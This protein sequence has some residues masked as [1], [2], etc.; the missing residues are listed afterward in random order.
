MIIKRLNHTYLS[1][2]SISCLVILLLQVCLF[3]YSNFKYLDA[4]DC[5][6]FFRDWY[7]WT[8]IL[9]NVPCALWTWFLLSRCSEIFY[10]FYK[11]AYDK[12]MMVTSDENESDLKPGERVRL[13]LN[14]YLE[15]IFNFSI[16]YMLASI[17]GCFNKIGKSPFYIW[18]AIYYS[19][20]TIT[21]LGYGDYVS[22]HWWPKLLAVYE[23]LCGFM[24]LIVSFGV[25]TRLDN[26][27]CEPCCKDHECCKDEKGNE[28]D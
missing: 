1:V 2:A 3:P 28:K 7:L 18:D 6:S 8:I 23:V 11:D 15:L 22:I 19:G 21:T 10:A 25:Y 5:N 13:A 20:V 17:N 14:S 27:K 24:L 4:L 12:L 9:Y 16:L 26:K